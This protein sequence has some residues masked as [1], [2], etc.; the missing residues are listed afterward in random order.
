MIADVDRPLWFYGSVSSI[1]AAL[2]DMFSQTMLP[3][4]V[5]A[6]LML[7]L[8]PSR[9]VTL[10]WLFFLAA[11]VM[12]GLTGRPGQYRVYIPVLALLVIAP[13]VVDTVQRQARQRLAALAIYF[14]AVYLGVYQLAAQAADAKREIR[15]A[16]LD[17]M[18]LPPGPMVLWGLLEQSTYP[19]FSDRR[20]RDR[21]VSGVWGD[22]YPNSVSAA[23]ERAGN[24]VVQ[25]L[26]RGEAI[27]ILTAPASRWPVEK[28]GIYCR[29][30]LNGR[31]L[32]AT[33]I[34]NSHTLSV[35]RIRC[36][37]I[38]G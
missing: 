8:M 35:F 12:I 24:G 32:E 26:R 13:L 30:H 4:V 2:T 22:I 20:I 38:S 17:F 3:F 16:N 18:A 15:Q 9:T 27:Q 34:Y 6:V 1:V 19:V 29:E 7:V 33:E 28:L 23:D 11:L 21:H 36:D 14:C 10:S 37:V 25:R 5:A 31:Q